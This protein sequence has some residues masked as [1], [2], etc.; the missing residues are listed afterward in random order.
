MLLVLDGVAMFACFLLDTVLSIK[1]WLN[2]F[3]TIFLKCLLFFK[4]PFRKHVSMPI[5]NSNSVV[6]VDQCVNAK[7]LGM[8]NR[9]F[10]QQ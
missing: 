1:M 5:M 10:H 8:L 6:V 3:C 7:L 4:S 2:T 9:L